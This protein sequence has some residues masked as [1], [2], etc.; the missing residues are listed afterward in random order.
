MMVL[1]TLRSTVRLRP[2]FGFH[3]G[4]T[5][6]SKKDENE[7]TGNVLFIEACNRVQPKCSKYEIL[8][9]EN[10]DAAYAW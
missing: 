9:L 3:V 8:E 1:S 2:P 4:G 10:S 7:G 5:E 6:A